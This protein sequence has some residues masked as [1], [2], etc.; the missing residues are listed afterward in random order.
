[1]DG[2]NQKYINCQAQ[3]EREKRTG[4]RRPILEAWKGAPDCMGK[5]GQNMENRIV[6][7]CFSV[8]VHWGQGFSKRWLGLV[9][10]ILGLKSL[11]F[12]E[13]KNLI[14]QRGT[15]SFMIF[16]SWKEMCQSWPPWHITRVCFLEVVMCVWLLWYQMA[17]GY[18]LGS[19]RKRREGKKTKEAIYKQQKNLFSMDDVRF[20]RC[21]PTDTILLPEISPQQRHFNWLERKDPEG[22]LLCH[23]F[24]G[25]KL[26]LDR[27]FF[28]FFLFSEASGGKIC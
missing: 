23:F 7:W 6:I 8:A 12:R 18:R 28:L 11:H 9:G 4:G 24:P 2:Q 10:G 14:F 13:G 26:V 20:A 5:I 15:W 3:N 25:V 21:G 17:S 16:F 27:S 1:M 22:L 19:F